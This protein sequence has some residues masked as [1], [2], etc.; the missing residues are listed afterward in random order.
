LGPEGWLIIGELSEAECDQLAGLELRR[1]LDD[2]T[3]KRAVQNASAALR[4]RAPPN[5]ARLL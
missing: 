3:L 5:Q 2:V 4:S 1:Q